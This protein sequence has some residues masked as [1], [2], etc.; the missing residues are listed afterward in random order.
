[1]KKTTSAKTAPK[2]A[3]QKS[4]IVSAKDI[5][6]QRTAK[7]APKAKKVKPTLSAMVTVADQIAEAATHQPESSIPAKAKKVRTPKPEAAAPVARELDAR[8]PP[9]GTLIE[10]KDRAGKVRCSCTV[11]EDGR[12]EYAGKIFS[13][14]SAAALAAARDLGLTNRTFNGYV[15]WGL[16]KP[17]RPVA[18]PVEA[19]KVLGTKFIERLKA[20]FASCAVEQ[21]AAVAANA[22]E[23]TDAIENVIAQAALNPDS[24]K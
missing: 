17:S 8:L 19:V 20:V 6:A 9:V 5:A 15:F 10:K 11:L 3:S 1:M 22:T 18:D 14:I 13:S 16:S 12:I 24:R 7:K 4:S 23:I 21:V 2:K